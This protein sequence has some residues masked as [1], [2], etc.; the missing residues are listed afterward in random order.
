MLSFKHKCAVF[1]DIR[2]DLLVISIIFIC[3]EIKHLN[4]LFVRLFICLYFMES[5]IQQL[6]YSLACCCTDREYLAALLF[7]EFHEL[8]KLVLISHDIHLV[9]CNDLRLF[10]KP[11]IVLLKL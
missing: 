8:I 4:R 6:G 1:I 7:H 11:R 9:G 2:T 3:L 5:L 10:E